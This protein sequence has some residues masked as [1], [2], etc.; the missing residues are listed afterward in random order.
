MTAATGPR[1]VP[2]PRVVALARDVERLARHVADLDQ[3][4]GDVRAQT[5]AT[6]AMPAR[7][8]TAVARAARPVPDQVGGRAPERVW[9]SSPRQDRS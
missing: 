7:T 3:R 8:D 9:A 2:D 1:P 6:R 4:Q 5:R